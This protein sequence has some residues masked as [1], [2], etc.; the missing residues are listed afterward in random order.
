[1]SWFISYVAEGMAVVEGAAMGIGEVDQGIPDLGTGG[2]FA[3][4][5]TGVTVFTDPDGGDMDL[6]PIGDRMG[7]AII[8][9]PIMEVIPTPVMDT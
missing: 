7:E 9:I 4:R 2:T 6:D 1:M 8:R 5:D 3:A